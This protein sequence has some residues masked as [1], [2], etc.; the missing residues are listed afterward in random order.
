LESK[1]LDRKPEYINRIAIFVFSVALHIVGLYV[2]LHAKYNYKVFNDREKATAVVL[3]PKDAVRLPKVP[4]RIMTSP[5][6]P[7]PVIIK[8]GRNSEPSAQGQGKAEQGEVQKPATPAGGGGGAN[9]QV[10][11]T[12]AQ[13]SSAGTSGVQPG[14]GPFSGFHLTYPKNAPLNLAKAP[15]NPLDALLRP[16]RYRDLREIN[17]SK[18][19]GSGASLTG[20]SGGGGPSGPGGK[21]SGGQS[22]G[23]GVSVNIRRYDLAPWANQVLTKIQKNWSL[24]RAGNAGWKGE[25]GISVMIA[26]SGELLSAE[27]ATPSKVEVLDQ[28]ALKALQACAPFPPLPADFPNSSLELYFVFEYGH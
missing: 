19:A 16:N 10:A 25:V 6:P 21:G 4:N 8:P 18:Y 2:I 7:E 26:K 15:E 28:A 14:E 23:A 9:A 5:G 11:G 12:A 24:G 1:I 27:I 20:S 13:S 17:F 3:L 22:R